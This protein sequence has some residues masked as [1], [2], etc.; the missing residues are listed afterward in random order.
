[1]YRALVSVLCILKLFFEIVFF[2]F[3]QG[4]K[5]LDIKIFNL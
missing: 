2:I 4:V 3:E 5:G 1:M